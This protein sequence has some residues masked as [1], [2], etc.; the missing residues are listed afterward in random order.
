MEFVYL[1]N[2]K[3]LNKISNTNNQ[4][5]WN[6]DAKWAQSI[7]KKISS[8]LQYEIEIFKNAFVGHSFRFSLIK[9]EIEQS[10][11]FTFKSWAF[12]FVFFCFYEFC[13]FFFERKKRKKIP[14]KKKKF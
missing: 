3:T 2:L 4:I 7:C 9:K 1:E 8:Y 10:L 13:F 6:Q 5:G 11:V 12:F 14:F